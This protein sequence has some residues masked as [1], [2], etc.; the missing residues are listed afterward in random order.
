[1][2]NFAANLTGFFFFCLLLFGMYY[3]HWDDGADEHEARVNEYMQYFQKEFNSSGVKLQLSAS[4]VEVSGFPFSTS[5]RVYK[6]ELRM[7]LQGHIYYLST[8]YIDLTPTDNEKLAYEIGLQRKA[9]VSYKSGANPQ[10]TYQVFFSEKPRVWVRSND[11]GAKRKDRYW[12]E[13]GVQLP[14]SITMDVAAGST[15][16]RAGFKLMA[17]GQPTWHYIPKRIDYPVRYLVEL[18]RSVAAR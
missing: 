15:S 10:E 16:K 9:I 5:V 13:Y 7:S 2:N 3:L 4:S 6:P 18:V 12:N 8:P 11:D 1:M 14:A 17:T